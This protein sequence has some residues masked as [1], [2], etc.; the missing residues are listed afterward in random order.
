[1]PGDFPFFVVLEVDLSG[2]GTGSVSYSVTTQEELEIVELYQQSTG[3]FNVTDIR[4]SDGQHYSNASSVVPIPG[5][6]FADVGDG[7]NP[8]PELPIPIRLSGG[9]VIYID[10]LDTSG[11][12][13][14][15]TILLRC[16]RRFVA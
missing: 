7:Y 3:T 16:V 10:L 12:A 1:M 11:V 14:K 5:A 8:K 6:F 13:N 9:G 2:N 15:V 4:G